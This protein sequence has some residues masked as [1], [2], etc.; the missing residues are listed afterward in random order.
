MG[1]EEMRETT[2]DVVLYGASGFVGRQTVRYFAAHVGD[3]VRWAIAGRD[4]QKLE[5]V[6]AQ[7]KLGSML[8]FWWLTVKIRGRWRSL[9]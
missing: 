4:L 7:G 5:L 8:I 9:P 3:K 6:R 2:Y 1:G